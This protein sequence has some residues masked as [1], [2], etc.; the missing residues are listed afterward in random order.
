MGVFDQIQEVFFQSFLR[1]KGCDIAQG[2]W[3]SK[4]LSAEQMKDVLMSN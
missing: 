4:P 2:Y 1:D 3:Y